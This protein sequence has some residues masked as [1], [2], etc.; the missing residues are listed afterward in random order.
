MNEL[1]TLQKNLLTVAG[2]LISG[3]SLLFAFTLPEILEGAHNAGVVYTY[4][5]MF[6][7][8]TGYAVT[9]FGGIYGVVLT[10]MKRFDLI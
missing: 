1:T 5:Q 7:V 10:L 2:L 6:A 3:L 9:L 8:I 4:P